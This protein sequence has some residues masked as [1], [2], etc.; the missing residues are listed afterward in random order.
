MN[1]DP[2]GVKMS[3][4]EE[5]HWALVELQGLGYA[6]ARGQEQWRLTPAGEKAASDLLESLRAADRVMLVMHMADDGNSGLD[7]GE[8]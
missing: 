4:I 2:K 3:T 7:N 5:V 6:E 8:R 1:T